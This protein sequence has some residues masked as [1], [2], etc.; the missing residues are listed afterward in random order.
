M[1]RLGVSPGPRK[2]L[3]PALNRGKAGAEYDA[4]DELL[5]L[6]PGTGAVAARAVP[7]ESEIADVRVGGVWRTAQVV[8]QPRIHHSNIWRSVRR[9]ISREL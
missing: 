5:A 9:N 4:E 6:K 2:V 8:S 1:P 3:E 7:R